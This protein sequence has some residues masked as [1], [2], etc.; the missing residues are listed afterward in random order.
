MYLS[1]FYLVY[2]YIF[3]YIRFTSNGCPPA[4]CTNSYYLLELKMMQ[5][6]VANLD[7]WGQFSC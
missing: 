6:L 1:L 7:R 3:V 4:A 2:C 5:R